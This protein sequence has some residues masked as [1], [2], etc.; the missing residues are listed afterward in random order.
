MVHGPFAPA[1][2]SAATYLRLIDPSFNKQVSSYEDLYSNANELVRKAVRQSDPNPSFVQ[3]QMAFQSLP[4]PEKSP[5]GLRIITNRM[6]GVNDHDTARAAAIPVYAQE[7]GGSNA[8]FDAWWRGNA[9]PYAF[10]FMRMAPQDQQALV[11]KL[12]ANPQ[13][14][15]EI[16]KLKQQVAFINKNGL[17]Q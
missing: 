8:G 16:E 4:V 10:V 3:T 13:G 12:N 15:R 11:A 17:E 1:A 7:H 14:Q 5:E 2:Q 6:I 9:S